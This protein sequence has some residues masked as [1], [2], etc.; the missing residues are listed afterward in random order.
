M[1]N[2]FPANFKNV[3]KPLGQVEWAKGKQQLI[4]KYVEEQ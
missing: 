3:W 1:P 2:L 4:T